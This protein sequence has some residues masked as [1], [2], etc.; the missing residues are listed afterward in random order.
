MPALRWRNQPGQEPSAPGHYRKLSACRRTWEMMVVM[1][2]KRRAPGYSVLSSHP[3]RHGHGPALSWAK[4][5]CRAESQQ[6]PQHCSGGGKK[7]G[8]VGFLQRAGLSFPRSILPLKL[9]CSLRVFGGDGIDL[10][11]G[12][13]SIYGLYAGHGFLLRKADTQYC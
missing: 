4:R 1:T 3:P 10:K 9:Q 5:F 12:C 8:C 6:K 11:S 13:L 7:P 2:G